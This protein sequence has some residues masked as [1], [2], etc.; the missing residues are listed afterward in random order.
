MKQ[1]RQKSQ[2][3]I[4]SWQEQKTQT[5]LTTDSYHLFSTYSIYPFPVILILS[6]PT[7]THEIL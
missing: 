5:S 2:K 1:L 3:E 4:S 6:S 7:I